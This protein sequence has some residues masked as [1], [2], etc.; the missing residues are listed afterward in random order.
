MRL[1]TTVVLIVKPI[2][3]MCMP[4]LRSENMK[5]IY[6]FEAKSIAGAAIPLS[7]YADVIKRYAPQDNPESIAKDI[8]VALAAT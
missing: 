5:S 4:K 1:P 2:E 7:N 8:E 6:D 3:K